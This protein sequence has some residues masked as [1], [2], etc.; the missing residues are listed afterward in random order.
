MT[1]PSLK[2]EMAHYERALPDSDD[3]TYAYLY[4]VLR[5]RVELNRQEGNRRAIMAHHAGGG[6]TPTMA[7]EKKVAKNNTTNKGNGGD[8]RG[9]APTLRAKSK[10]RGK[11]E[12]AHAGVCTG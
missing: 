7:A 1:S 2:E 12:D 11:G 9:R 4:K 3:K 10:G 5:R 6:N 8:A